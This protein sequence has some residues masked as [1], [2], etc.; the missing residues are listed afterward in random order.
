M[1]MIPNGF[2]K[3][4]YLQLKFSKTKFLGLSRHNMNQPITNFESNI[5]NCIILDGHTNLHTI[6][7]TKLSKE[8]LVVCTTSKCMRY[9][10]GDM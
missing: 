10:K 6:S 9:I 4:H 1:R 5:T 2:S 3:T 8:L 7:C